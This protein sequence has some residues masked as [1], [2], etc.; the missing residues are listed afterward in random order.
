MP[1]LDPNTRVC[2]DLLERV[3]NSRELN[4]AQRLREL[5]CY[6]G[7]RS[8]GAHAS[9]LREQ[10][11][12]AALFGRPKEYDTST[13]N[14]VRVNVSELRK[15]LAQYFMEEGAHEPIVME[16]PRGGYVP[17]FYPRKAPVEIAEPEP[18][19]L[20]PPPDAEIKFTEAPLADAPAVET[21]LP[22]PELLLAPRP[23]R[24]MVRLL[25]LGLGLALAGCAAL[26]WQNRSLRARIQPWRT[27]AVRAAFWGEF[28]GSG[29][30][31]DIV[32]ADTSFGLAQDVLGRTI[33]LNDYL[34]Y[35]YRNFANDPS[36]SPD[37]REALRL[38]LNR[39]N[40][41]IG[42]FQVAERLMEFGD[43]SKA[44]RLE[45]A[46]GCT[47]ESIE[48]NNVILI[49]GRE[50][51]PWVDLYKSRMNFVLEYDPSTQRTFIVN[52][53][54]QPGER[55][56]YDAS[57]DHNLGYSVVSFLPNLSEHRYA[58]ILSGSDSQATQAAG[59]FITSSEGLAQIRQKMAHGAFPYFEVV[60][61][62]SRLVG[63]TIDTQ[64]LAYRVQ[65][66]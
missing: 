42:D 12:G 21:V 49:G 1:Y 18:N 52:R 55:A 4:R 50:S 36:L 10:E 22:V 8:Q 59:D 39:N 16:I 9:V 25:W 34:D 58:L 33:S 45:G 27:D 30:E 19:L 47:P 13:D 40:G 32:A 2:Q 46:R 23:S 65:A 43:H 38:V 54:P 11:I 28:F 53:R 7:K 48:T 17:V 5:L 3:V 24:T 63:T 60:L 29:D 57:L 26:L 41:S 20:P 31:V 35:Q 15:R 66:R 44:V 37:R 62:S 56:V 14:I 51:N 64:M 61:G 6:L